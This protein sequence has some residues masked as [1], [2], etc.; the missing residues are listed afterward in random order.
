MSPLGRPNS[1]P[2]DD[3]AGPAAAP[4]MDVGGPHQK[5]GL[6]SWLVPR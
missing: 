5:S 2:P 1:C 4:E 3:G 6:L